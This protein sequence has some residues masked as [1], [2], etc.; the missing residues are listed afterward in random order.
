MCGANTRTQAADNSGLGETWRR[1]FVHFIRHLVF[2]FAGR[3][4]RVVG[5]GNVCVFLGT[6]IR[7]A[8]RVV[9]GVAVGIMFVRF[10][11]FGSVGRFVVCGGLGRFFRVTGGR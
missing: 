2:F 7:G 1:R 8:G 9:L 6:L 10:A 5:T 3:G 4:G 11:A